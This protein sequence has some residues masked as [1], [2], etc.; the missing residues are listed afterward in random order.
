MPIG[1]SPN[2]RKIGFRRHLL[3]S[4]MKVLDGPIGLASRV[5]LQGQSFGGIS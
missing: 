5:V 1:P 4:D 3:Q 2:I